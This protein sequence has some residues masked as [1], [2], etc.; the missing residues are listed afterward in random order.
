MVQRYLSARSQRDASRAVFWSSIVV[1]FQFALF[2]WIGV[3]LACFYAQ[4]EFTPPERG[5]QVFAHFIVNF[6]PKNVG[7]IGLMLAAILAA[8][9]STL[10]S[11]LS[12]SV[13]ALLNDF[14]V[15][16]CKTPPSDAKQLRLSRWLTVAFGIL[17]IGIGI[18]ASTLDASVVSNALTIAGFSAGLLLGIFLLG[19]LM[20][21]ISETSVLIGA[22]VGLIVLSFV[23]FVLRDDQGNA[24]VAWPWLAL[25][26]SSITFSVGAVASKIFPKQAEPA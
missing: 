19:I 4:P 6:F 3:Q 1:F 12:A 24:M 15:P 13:S 7:L 11:S 22:A 20:P 17:Q 25:I 16:S 5:D 26:G 10:S 21:G 18:W 8:A 2:L 23:T 14:Y 9:M